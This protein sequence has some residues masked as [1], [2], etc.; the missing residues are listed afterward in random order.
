VIFSFLA[1]RALATLVLLGH[2]TPPMQESPLYHEP[3]RPQFHFTARQWT[4]HKLNPQRHEEGWINDLN[5]LIYYDGEYHLFAQRWATCWLHAVSR[6]LVHWTELPPAFWEET[7]GNGVQSGTCVIDYDNTS[8]LA[9]DKSHPAMVAFWSRFDN[10]SQCLCYSLDHGRTWTR[11]AGNPIMH[12]PERDPKVFWYG[13]GRHWVMVMYGQG[14]YNILTSPDL[15][16][17]KDEHNPIPDSFECPDFFEMPIDGNRSD[18]RWV[19]VQGN[20]RYSIGRFDGRKFTEETGRFQC[21]V[22]SNFYATQTWANTE[23]GDDRRIQAAWMR[24]SNFPDMPFNQQISFPCELTLRTTPAGLRLYRKPIREVALLHRA[25]HKLTGRELADGQSL[26]VAQTGDLFHLVAEVE[27]SEHATLTVDLCGVKIVIA[28]K[29]LRSGGQPTGVQGVVKKVEILLDR[30]SVETFLNDG[31]ISAT[32]YVL[33]RGSGVGL[34]AE[35]GSVALHSV[36]LYEM[37]S[38]WKKPG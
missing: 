9:R 18:K 23:T 33:P 13:P 25:A 28:A 16:H 20:G 34:S 26:K 14:Q 3:L 5:G 10:S 8:G 35:G 4:V 17:W 6:D 2:Q 29:G 32:T 22:G 36:R 27:I 1:Y 7:P 30:G 21:D 24:D 15:L 38:A 19:L 31:E 12:H 11:Y 37:K